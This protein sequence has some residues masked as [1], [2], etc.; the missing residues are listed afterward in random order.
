MPLPSPETAKPTS[1]LPA[2]NEESRELS[3]LTCVHH[4]ATRTRCHNHILA[5]IVSL[6]QQAG[7]LADTK[8]VPRI[9]RPQDKYFVA[10]MFSRTMDIGN[11][12]GVALDVS[13]VHDFHGSA[14]NPTLN[15]T[16]RHQDLDLALYQRAQV[17]VDKYREGYAAPGLRHAFL[18][19]VVST[20]GRI[21]RELLRLLFVLVGR[22]G[23]LAFPS[24]PWAM[25]SMSTLRFTAG[26][27]VSSSAA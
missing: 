26:V 16:L 7:F 23:R 19:A 13:T 20:S 4:K 6:F 3:F 1:S 8:D 11:L 5:C 22:T 2:K 15:G 18:P 9:Q 17:K 10:D 27:G 12:R 21:H 25:P 14:D 24:R